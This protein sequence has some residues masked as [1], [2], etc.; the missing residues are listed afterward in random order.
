MAGKHLSPLGVGDVSLRGQWALRRKVGELVAP[1]GADL[2][3][4]TVLPGYTSLVGAW[5]KRKFGLPFVLDYQDPWVSDWGAAQPRLS[6]AGLAHWLATRLEPGA[7]ACAD[8]LTAVSDDT[9]RTLRQR[10]LMRNGLPAETIPIGADASD[11]A[12]AAGTG[13]K[14]DSA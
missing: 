8:A 1:G 10:G 14:P 5:A 11:H 13:P 7:V 9:L 6:K 2:I 3:F 12:A 4:C